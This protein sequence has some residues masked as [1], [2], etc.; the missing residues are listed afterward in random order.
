VTG[1]LLTP[2]R[3]W[4]ERGIRRKP[5]LLLGPAGKTA[6]R[7]VRKGESRDRKRALAKSCRALARRFL[8]RRIVPQVVSW[9]PDF[10]PFEAT[11]RELDRESSPREVAR[12][13]AKN[14]N[15]GV[16]MREAVDRRSGSSRDYESAALTT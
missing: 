8:G 11:E 13:A 7:Q 9:I 12:N 4:H 14:N 6:P 5:V 16:V 1:R 10:K 2:K 3:E 15:L